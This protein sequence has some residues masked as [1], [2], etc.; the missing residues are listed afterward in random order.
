MFQPLRFQENKLHIIDQ[1]R[2]PFE[3]KWLHIKNAR[4]MYQAIKK[5]QIR[6]A[7]ALGIAGIFG[8]WL[9]VKDEINC[10]ANTFL[11]KVQETGDFLK[12]ARPTAVNLFWAI[13]RGISVLKRGKSMNSR[14]LAHLLLQEA[15]HL[16]R[17][18][19][20]TCRRIGEHGQTLIEEE[21][22]IL[23]HCNAGALAT[24]AYGTALSVIYFAQQ[25]GK[26]VHVYVDETRPLLQGARLT[27]WELQ[28]NNIPCTLICDNM[29][30][31]TVKQK[32]IG[33]IITGADRIALNGDTANKIGTYNLAL[34]AR[35]HDIP[36]YIAAPLSTFDSSTPNGKGI[37]IEERPAEEVR[38]FHNT[39]SAPPDIPVFNP[40]FDVTPAELITAYITEKGIHSPHT[41]KGLLA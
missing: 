19:I 33:C 18:D 7:P 13:D 6:G 1:T 15:T 4:E 30:A 38:N 29:A 32:N 17:E 36:F 39:P 37:V 41:I 11:K 26:R 31:Y 25:K 23:T 27:T 8:L 21:S 12:T 14:E 24:G 22:N 3:E 9:G 10:S 35:H 40:A 5:L 16:W 2:L 28:R 34:I 20:E